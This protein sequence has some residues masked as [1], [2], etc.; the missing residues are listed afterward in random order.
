MSWHSLRSMAGPEYYIYCIFFLFFNF[1]IGFIIINVS[2]P[3]YK[4]LTIPVLQA[5][6]GFEPFPGGSSVLRNTLPQPLFNVQ[7]LLAGNME[8]Q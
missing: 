6:H 8:V 2:V 4:I 3:K 1:E 7:D 5:S